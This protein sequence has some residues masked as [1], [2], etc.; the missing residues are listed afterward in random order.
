MKAVKHLALVLGMVL[1]LSSPAF[2][3]N[4]E[5]Y[6]SGATAGDGVWGTGADE[7]TWFSS[8]NPFTLNIVG[9]YG[10]KTTQINNVTLL[11]S[12][13]KNETGT[14]TFSNISDGI[15][16]LITTVTPSSIAV[17]DKDVL[18]AAGIDGYAAKET[19]LPVSFNNHDPLKS[20]ISDFVLYDLGS[21]NNNTTG[22]Y[23]Y[24][25]GA[26]SIALMPNA[27]GQQKSYAISYSGFSA[28]HFDVYGLLTNVN[29]SRTTYVWETNPGSH[30]ST[31]RSTGD[32]PV[33]E[34][35]TMLLFGPALLG[36]IGLKKK[37]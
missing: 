35:M 30:D 16:G 31:A 17:A 28:L 23:N 33:P 22:L 25:A 20:N 19:F 7:D 37:K 8:S 32:N 12:V 15:P 1:L 34:P 26:G 4:F 10:N 29:G 18:T 14:I 27:Q 3:W 13:P 11:V 6:I 2:A 5:T 9:V 24:D 36:L 21:F